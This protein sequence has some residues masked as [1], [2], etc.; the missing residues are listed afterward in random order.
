MATKYFY[1]AEGPGTG[2]VGV[3][4]LNEIQAQLATGILQETFYALEVIAITSF[5]E[6]Q[7]SVEPERWQ[8]LTTLLARSTGFRRVPTFQPEPDS[9]PP[10]E[11]PPPSPVRPTWAAHG[12]EAQTDSPYLPVA[13]SESLDRSLVR[14]YSDVSFPAKVFVNRPTVLRIRIT[15]AQRHEHDTALDLEFPPG[16]QELSLTVCVAAENLTIEEDPRAVLRVPRT[17]ASPPLH[18]RLSGE[19][20]GPGRVM[21]DFSQNGQ[22]RGSVDLEVAVVS[23]GKLDEPPTPAVSREVCLQ[24]TP[25]SA[26]DVTITVHEF[27][28]SP[29]R[30]HFTLHSQHPGLQH[31]PYVNH[32]DLGVVTLHENVSSWV[33]RHLEGLSEQATAMRC[34]DHIL[35][36]LG[37]K[38]YDQVLPAEAR[39]LCWLLEQSGVRSLLVLSDEPHIP[40]E[41][42]KPYRQEAAGVRPVSLPFWGES[43]ALARWV[44]GPAVRD[45]FLRNRLS[46]VA[47]GG[48][49]TASIAAMKRGMGATPATPS[50]HPAPLSALD[51]ALPG[52]ALE[53]DAVRSLEHQ[54]IQVRVLPARRNEVLV[55]LEEGDFDLFHVASHAHFGGVK[56]GDASAVLLED[57]VLR[58]IDLSPRMAAGL[59]RAAALIFFNGCQTGRVGYSLARLGAWGAE[60]I[61]LGCSGFIGTQW[62]VND[63]AALEFAREFYRLLFAGIPIAEAL[64]QS[65]LYLQS[66]HPNDPTWLAYCCFAHPLAR[67]DTATPG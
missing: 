12:S 22:P 30:L 9:E 14:R 43:L 7:S 48:D 41:L 65:R 61:R 62:D 26:P 16:V 25:S 51:P 23:Q 42:I 63:E 53:L 2:F 18:F 11:H 46:V 4:T 20:V 67:L 19:Q 39:E 49:S 1:V 52:T 50:I 33:E 28:Y 24:T 55:A 32:G 36:D 31:L 40:W 3:L 21:I 17:G 15:T 38:L 44:R 59:Q 5:R 27:Q 66:R 35:E 10:A 34:C 64:R 13:R 58:A 45:R 54:G 6:V 8:P 37:Q 60:L 47:P 29:G 57:G 56:S